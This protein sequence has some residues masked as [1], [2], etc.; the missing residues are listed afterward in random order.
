MDVEQYEIFYGMTSQNRTK[1]YFVAKDRITALKAAK[2]HLKV[3]IC[4]IIVSEAWI[5]DGSLY[6][7]NPKRRGQKKVWAASFL[8]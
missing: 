4:R 1:S 5:L 3:A 8:A 7:N 6:F 2:I